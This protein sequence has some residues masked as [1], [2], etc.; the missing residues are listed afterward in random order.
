[1]K[2]PVFFYFIIFLSFL[3]CRNDCRSTR[4]NNDELRIFFSHTTSVVFTDQFGE[5]AELYPVRKINQESEK[6]SY[7]LTKDLCKSEGSVKLTDVSGTIPGFLFEL[8]AS[9]NEKGP[10][11]HNLSV[12]NTF[13][14]RSISRQ[15]FTELE[16]VPGYDFIVFEKIPAITI[17][18][19]EYNDLYRI[20]DTRTNN[21]MNH[22]HR[23]LYSPY[24]GLVRLEF[25]N[26]QRVWNIKP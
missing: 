12:N 19:K 24:H 11:I 1:M 4:F 3:S 25:E 13:V 7:K 16:V 22:L 8:E 10:L 9:K 14:L 20:S 26:P 5:I 15:N 6:V 18:G 21:S 23:I 17:R 2:K